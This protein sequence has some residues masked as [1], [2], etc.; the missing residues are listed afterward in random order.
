[1]DYLL[2]MGYFLFVSGSNRAYRP[3]QGT[4][5]IHNFYCEKFLQI[6]AGET[7]A[8]CTWSPAV[9]PVWHMIFIDQASGTL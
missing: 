4:Q 9:S 1:V 3:Q 6:L 5:A 7:S 2:F 8:A